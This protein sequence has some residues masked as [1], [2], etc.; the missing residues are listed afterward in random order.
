MPI[1]ISITRVDS[2]VTQSEKAMANIATASITCQMFI[3]R[4]GFAA[5]SIFRG[6]R[7]PPLVKARHQGN[8]SRKDAAKHAREA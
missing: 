3:G 2:E 1:T 4:T 6:F 8:D 5:A 7:L